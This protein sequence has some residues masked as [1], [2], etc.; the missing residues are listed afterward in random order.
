MVQKNKTIPNFKKEK[1]SHN[2]QQQINE[3]MLKNSELRYRR[4]F[5]AAQDAILILDGETGQIIRS[6]KIF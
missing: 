1:E 4:L 2:T 5:E 3:D 6:F